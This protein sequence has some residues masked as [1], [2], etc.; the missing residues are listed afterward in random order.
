MKKFEI[1][2]NFCK[3]SLLGEAY[4]YKDKI[5]CV[6]LPAYYEH[7]VSTRTECGNYPL[8]ID[9]YWEH[10]DFIKELGLEPSV[11]FQ[12]GIVSDEIIQMYLNRGIRYFIV[13]DDNLAIRIKQLNPNTRITASIIKQLTVED[14][15]TK[16]LSMYDNIVLDFHLNRLETVKSLPKNHKYILMPNAPCYYDCPKERCMFH[17]FH[18]KELDESE[19]FC[20]DLYKESC[21]I[22]ANALHEYDEYIDGYKLQGREMNDYSLLYYM[23]HYMDDYYQEEACKFPWDLPYHRNQEI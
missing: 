8:D 22:P 3:E 7:S 1:P 11:L 21:W 13:R 6:Y 9:T 20:V 5:D 17:W 19:V 23:L 2:Y 10:V 16:D 4:R 12:S 15:N 14:L 18:G